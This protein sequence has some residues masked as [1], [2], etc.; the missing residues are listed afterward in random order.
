MRFRSR[1]PL[2]VSYHLYGVGGEQPVDCFPITFNFLEKT[3]SCTRCGPPSCCPLS[4]ISHLLP[5][6]IPFPASLSFS[7]LVTT[8]SAFPRLL[9]GLHPFFPHPQ[10]YLQ[11]IIAHNSHPCFCCAPQSQ[12]LS[13]DLH[14]PAWVWLPQ[15]HGPCCC[16]PS[17]AGR[18]GRHL[19]EGNGWCHHWQQKKESIICGANFLKLKVGIW[20][21]Q[22]LLQIKTKYGAAQKERENAIKCTSGSPCI[23]PFFN[24][25]W[26]LF[27]L[28][29]ILQMLF[30][31]FFIL[32]SLV[33]SFKKIL[34]MALFLYSSSVWRIPWNELA[35]GDKREEA[36]K[37]KIR[38]I[39][40]TQSSMNHFGRTRSKIRFQ[41]HPWWSW[42]FHTHTPNPLAC[43]R[44]DFMVIIIQRPLAYI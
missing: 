39:K 37:I 42:H 27:F 31:F 43:K 19:V 2:C 16:L 7:W 29:G 23:L 11:A 12:A 8:W 30:F 36:G 10:S 40:E 13:L 18:C 34:L 21:S 6:A 3:D 28:R 22:Q 14:G 33:K 20:H 26:L 32:D 4:P 35:P 9:S 24:N 17:P 25:R 5:A 41:I 38:N 1:L 44:L 15:V